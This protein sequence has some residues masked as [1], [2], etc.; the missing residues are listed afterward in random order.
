MTAGNVWI[1][2]YFPA[3]NARSPEIVNSPLNVH[4]YNL[5]AIIHFHHYHPLCLQFHQIILSTT[6]LTFVLV[7]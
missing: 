4:T 5:S 3:L 1:C 6:H 7:K 2:N